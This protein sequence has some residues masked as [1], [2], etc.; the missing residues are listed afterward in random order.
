MT[1]QHYDMAQAA[2]EYQYPT[3]LAIS[4]AASSLVWC[5]DEPVS[6]MHWA[7]KAGLTFVP[8]SLASAVQA[9]VHVGLG[10]LAA[11]YVPTAVIPTAVAW[12][13]TDQCMS[14]GGRPYV[15]G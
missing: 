3:N 10:S 2:S 13:V 7:S 8:T 11:T 5:A 9:A 1:Y 14:T 4:R 6:I 15:T 12:S